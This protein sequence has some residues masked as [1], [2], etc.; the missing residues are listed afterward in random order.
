M[1]LCEKRND[2]AI[3][4]CIQSP[5]VIV[6]LSDSSKLYTGKS[7]F[8]PVSAIALATRASLFSGIPDMP[9]LRVARCEVR[10]HMMHVETDSLAFYL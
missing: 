8:V 1:T 5:L 6:P 3:L 2:A 7:R 4:C 9:T 10:P